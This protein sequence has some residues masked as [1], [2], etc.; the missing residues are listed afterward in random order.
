METCE[1]YDKQ[2]K[3][4]RAQAFA[5]LKGRLNWYRFVLCLHVSA[6]GSLRLLP[7]IFHRQTNT[8]PCKMCT[9]LSTLLFVTF[10]VSH[11][12]F[13]SQYFLSLCVSMLFASSSLN[14]AIIP[15]HRVRRVY[16]FWCAK[17]I[18]CDWKTSTLNIQPM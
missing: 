14:K 17:T 12:W 1:K 4:D 2:Q 10:Y 15:W 8:S 13:R 11:L 18:L 5:Q 16:V 3:R 7:H 9:D 6:Q